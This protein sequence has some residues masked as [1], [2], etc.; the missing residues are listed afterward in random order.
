MR[1]L[2]QHSYRC[3]F[4]AYFL[5][6]G[7]KRRKEILDDVYVGGILHDLGQI[8]IASLHPDLLERITRVCK[9]KG[10]PSGMLE[11]FTVGL[12]HA[13]VGALIARKWNFPEQL[14]NAI[15]YHH[16]PSQSPAQGRDIVYSVYLANAICDMERERMGFDQIQSPVL[17]D[18][19]IETEDQLNKIQ[20]KLARAFE[21]QRAK[22][23]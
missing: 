13:E 12:N 20:E 10:I 4:Y 11:N 21:D 17:K 15:R 2:W 5:A 9:D 7:F 22:F 23:Q 14:V 3:A 6:K 16:E 18:F 1:S 8:V 19:G